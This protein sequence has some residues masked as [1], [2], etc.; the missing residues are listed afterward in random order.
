MGDKK[1]MKLTIEQIK[2]LIKEELR[3]VTASKTY[4]CGAIGPREYNKVY[5]MLSSPKMKMV[6][7]GFE[8][9]AAVCESDIDIEKV[10][11]YRIKK[12]SGHM[13]KGYEILPVDFDEKGEPSFLHPDGNIQIKDR[14]Y[15]RPQMVRA[16][17]IFSGG[18]SRD[19]VE[20]YGDEV[21][22]FMLIDN[23]ENQKFSKDFFIATLRA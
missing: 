14:V 13:F 15:G 2:Q 8:L 4:P 5:T 1:E 12:D 22:E 21:G 18:W 19:M 3:E 9:L 10:K 7:Q 17:G 23:S 11:K 6:A 16:S 20:E